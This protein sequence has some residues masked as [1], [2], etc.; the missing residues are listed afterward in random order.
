[1]EVEER[2]RVERKENIREEKRRE[3]KK[4]WEGEDEKKEVELIHLSGRQSKTEQRK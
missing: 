2:K 4:K 1:M 3:R